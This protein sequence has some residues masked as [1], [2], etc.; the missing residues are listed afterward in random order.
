ME[1]FFGSL[2]AEWV[3]DMGYSSFADAHRSIVNYITGYY[4]QTRRHQHNGGL[5]PN[6]AEELYWNSSKSVANIT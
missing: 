4:G 2:N 3:P 5:P 6:E 1:R